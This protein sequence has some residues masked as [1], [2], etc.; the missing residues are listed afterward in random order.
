MNILF[1]EFNHQL[2]E[3][4]FKMII[5]VNIFPNES[6]G[7]L[8]KIVFKASNNMKTK[9]FKCLYGK[10]KEEN[11]KSKNINQNIIVSLLCILIP[12]DDENYCLKIQNKC[13][14]LISKNQYIN[15]ALPLL[16]SS[17][18]TISSQKAREYFDVVVQS[19]MENNVD[20]PLYFDL[21]IN[22]F[23]GIAQFFISSK[24]FLSIACW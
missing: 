20:V 23:N 9:L 3:Y 10:L 14:K 1:Y 2:I 5:E 22:M 12:S 17:I 11:E 13:M 8:K 16:K 18:F 21:L 15:I 4:F 7:F 19:M 6:I 24:I